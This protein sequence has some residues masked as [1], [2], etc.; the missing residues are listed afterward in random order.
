MKLKDW[1]KEAEERFIKAG[2]PDSAL[3]ARLIAAGVLNKSPG[4]IRFLGET[5][6]EGRTLKILNE[7][8]LRREAGE[9]IQYIE[10]IAYFMDFAFYVD[11]NVLIPRQ[12]T[13]TLVELALEKIRKIPNPKVL[14]MCTGSGAIA[15][16]IALY[17]KD[18]RVIASDISSDALSVAKK[19][20]GL[21]NAS[22]EFIQSDLF[23]NIPRETF[24]L[25][26]VNPPYLTK[27]DM[28]CL[29][30]EVKREP[31]LALFGGEDGLEI[32]RRIAR[33]IHT[34]LK[35][36]AFALLEVGQG[37]E[38]DV[39]ALLKNETVAEFGVQKDL[40]GIDRVVWIRSLD[41]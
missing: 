19:N 29:Q 9:P 2:C 12:D 7:R 23:E 22:A 17:R 14:D 39:L 27:R 11:E 16:S 41:Q 35:P 18:A 8:L 28:Q 37:Q 40:C 20:A 21:M 26:T 31:A 5:E 3:D 10:N 34:F 25:I 1:L 4:E 13:E 30:K 36:G 32:Y 24:D 38:K 15:L 6:A 33:E